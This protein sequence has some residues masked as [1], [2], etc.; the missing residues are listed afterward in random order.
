MKISIALPATEINNNIPFTKQSSSLS[1]ALSSLSLQ[2]K[3]KDSILK[4]DDVTPQDTIHSILL[5]LECILSI[6]SY[7]MEL[8]CRGTFLD[9]E[10]KLWD[11]RVSNEKEILFLRFKNTHQ[12][13]YPSNSNL[14][15]NLISP[16]N[17]SASLPVTIN[18]LKESLY[19]LM[20]RAENQ[21]KNNKN[22]KRLV[23]LPKHS[24][25]FPRVSVDTI[26][27]FTACKE[28]LNNSSDG[29]TDEEG[30]T[31]NSES[32]DDEM[33]SK[34]SMTNP[35]IIFSDVRA[36]LANMSCLKR[37]LEQHDDQDIQDDS[38]ISKVDINTLTK[39]QLSTK[40]IE[41]DIC[42]GDSFYFAEVFA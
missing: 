1:S 3:S 8:F 21:I 30:E 11:H 32:S 7:T 35:T 23:L 34:V 37:F 39:G 20:K 4:I 28:A 26:R 40:L 38:I 15:I 19:D 31:E 27:R 10:S 6:P 5:Y 2:R 9:P 42:D 14:T 22:R 13:K 36:C 17:P 29:Q 25:I 41:Y 33:E 16:Y 18:P 24:V 12:S